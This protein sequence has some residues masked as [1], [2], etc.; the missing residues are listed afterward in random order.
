MGAIGAPDGLAPHER[1]RLTIGV[2]LVSN[3]PII[4]LD[5]PTSGL[6]ARAAAIV[7]RVVKNVASTGRT[8][9]CTIHQPSA[10]LFF[11]FDDLLLLARGGYEAYFGPMGRRGRSLVQYLSSVPGIPVYPPGMN[12]ASWMLDALQGMDSSGSTMSSPK[13]AAAV[14]QGEELQKA[15]FGSEAWAAAR[16]ELDT[17][18]KPKEGVIKVAFTSQHARS[19]P[20]QAKELLKRQWT[21]H[22]RNIPLNFFRWIAM[23][24]LSLLFGTIWY[25]IYPKATDVGGVQSLVAGIFMTVAFV[26]MINMNMLVPA[27]LSVRAAFYRE[28]ASQMYDPT[29]YSLAWLLTELPWLAIMVL[30]PTAM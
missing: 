28:Q 1:K 25:E 12:P 13:A 10:E 18:S 5:E 19:F 30:Q 17:A 16:P 29:A 7:M 23:M 24:F 22:S 14:P 8:I 3:A 26:S 21:F 27:L 9:I 20:V 4:F 6:D 2:E 11:L 15:Y